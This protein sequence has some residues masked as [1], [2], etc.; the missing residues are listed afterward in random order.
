[1]F[2]MLLTI[3]FLGAKLRYLTDSVL[4]GMSTFVVKIAL[5]FMIVSMLPQS[6]TKEMLWHAGPFLVAAFCSFVITFAFGIL[7][8]KITGLA[9]DRLSIHYAECGFS[10]SVFMGLPLILA[11][12]GQA[13]VFYLML[14]VVLETILVWTFGVYLCAPLGQSDWRQNFR[15]NIHKV[16]N[17]S[18]IALLV[19]F[20]MILGNFAPG[21]IV[22]TTLVNIG[23]TCTPIAMIFVGGS[24]YGL[25]AVAIRQH[26]SGFTI[27]LKMIFAPL[28][29][30]YLM[31][32]AGIFPYQALMT[33]VFI[34]SM[35]S[36]VIITMLAKTMGTDSA[37]A[38]SCILIT[39]LCSLITVPLVIY[40]IG[41]F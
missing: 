22:Q 29:V 38:S 3:G 36:M 19:A 24:L 12:L 27:L 13:G 8:A 7:T 25:R 34:V 40:L 37:Y 31:H 9:G 21:G 6:V 32:A 15:Q 5:P 33:L 4:T 41:L 14:Y 39:T 23:N 18:T 1:M 30:Y 16:V 28:I 26:L 17:P 2:A 20:G 10:N 11:F 35:P